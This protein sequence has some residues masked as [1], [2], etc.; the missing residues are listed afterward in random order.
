MRQGCEILH[1]DL[2]MRVVSEGEED[3]NFLFHDFNGEQ[4]TRKLRCV[5]VFTK[6]LLF[7]GNASFNN[8]EA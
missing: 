7:L 1:S 8:E 4:N 5:Y 3:R 2:L 6:T